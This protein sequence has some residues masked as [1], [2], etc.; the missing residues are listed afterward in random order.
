MLAGIFD[1]IVVGSGSAGGTLAARLSEGGRHRVLVLEA[2]GS[3]KNLLVSMPA[4]WAAMTYSPK[5]SWM[6]KTEPEKY[7]GGR[8]MKMPRGKLV[9]GSSSINGMIYIRGHA[10]DY[11]DWVTAGATGWSWPEL[12]PHFVRTEDQARIRNAWHGRGG[13]LAASDLPVVHPLTHAMIDA[14]A[15]AGLDRVDDFN[16]GQAKG[17]GVFQVNFRNGRRSSIASNAIEPALRRPNLKL[18]MRAMVQ[19]IVFEGRRATGVEYSMPDGSR[20]LATA[21]HE[22][23][24][25]AGAI[26]SPQLLMVSGIGPASQ[27]QAL[28]IA[29][30]ADLP[31]VGENLQDH[32]SA[33]LC[34]RLKTGVRGMN[35][36]FRGLKLAGSVLRYLTSRAGPMV[37]PPAE[38]GCYLKSDPEL[39]Y[40]DIQVFGL[41]MTGQTDDS[42]SDKAPQPDSFEGMTLGPFQGRPFSR[43]HVRLKSRDMEQHPAITMNYLHDPRD[44]RALI[45][46]LRWLRDL[47]KQPALVGLID[48]E[49]RPGPQVQ[50]D[51]QW[52]AWMEPLLTTAYHPVGTCRMGHADDPMAVC[53]PDLRVR[54]V[55]GLRVIDASVMPNLICG[56]TNAT[57]VVIGD[58]GADLVLGLAPLAPLHL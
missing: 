58:K 2:G 45:W 47:A 40:N 31:G 52:L 48:A 43:G 29:L 8:R 19:R 9:G 50:T 24:V 7:A 16:D 42:S 55:Q 3:H 41:P 11:A 12:L 54:G 1:Y 13:P 44:R 51:E 53:T 36:T 30:V 38:F 5:F 17:A 49:I 14:A 25:C 46:S 32:V 4:G 33:P 6:H 37:S 34:W 57:S 56:N 23:L 10:Q 28:G 22:V 26:Q 39:A 15:Q 18:V 27:L 35:S 21:S 20:H